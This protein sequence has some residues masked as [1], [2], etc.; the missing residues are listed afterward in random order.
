MG[1][2]VHKGT[3]YGEREKHTPGQ[4]LSLL[5]QIEA[6]HYDFPQNGVMSNSGSLL[7]ITRLF[8]NDGRTG[9]QNGVYQE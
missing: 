7:P 5:R 1:E 3:E 6:L 8:G 4:I 9:K 2:T